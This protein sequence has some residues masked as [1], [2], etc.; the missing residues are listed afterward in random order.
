MSTCVIIMGFDRHARLTSRAWTTLCGPDLTICLCNPC[1]NAQ[2]VLF[3]ENSDGS[4]DVVLI[5]SAEV[6][7][8]ETYVFNFGERSTADKWL[9]DNAS[10]LVGKTV[11]LVDPAIEIPV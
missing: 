8:A 2:R 3:P 1:S 6:K 10:E 7:P 4:H 9:L 11:L 5:G